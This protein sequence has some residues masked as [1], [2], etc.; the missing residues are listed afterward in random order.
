MNKKERIGLRTWI[1]VD[2]K[3][4]AHNFN[5]F[6]SLISKKTKLMAV[7]KSNAYGHSIID[8]AREM[9]HLGADFLGVDS[10]VEGLALRKE[11]INTPILVLGYTL[12][13]MVVSALENNISLS[14]SNF[15][16][17]E[18][19]LANQKNFNKS[20]N[21]HIK[22]DT[23]MHRQGFLKEDC[24]KVLKLLKSIKNNKINIEGLF[25]HFASA[26]NPSFP[27]DTE[28]QVENFKF[29]IKEFKENNFNPIIH[30]SA[31]GGT[32]LFPAY[33]FDMVR[34]GIGLYGLWPAKEVKHALSPKI[35]LKPILVW[36]SLISEIKKIPKGEHVGYDLTEFLEVNTVLGVVPIGYWHGYPRA[37]SSIGRI[38][39][40]GIECRVLGRVSMDMICIDI[41]KI[42]N[43]KV[44]D[45]II[46]VGNNSESLCSMEGINAILDISWYETI[47]RL[48]PLIK[49]LYI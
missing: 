6:R 23:G 13:E 31:T 7:I 21:I 47:T 8:F 3:S 33:H 12:P 35:I 29:W 45:E 36:K 14:I 27:K 42:K 17:L 34:I 43:P 48:N 37:L 19:I 10:I 15:E 2:K 18:Y 46:I 28:M 40:G 25:T 38:L 22:I 26:K 1:E 30:A 44:G 11:G 49:R 39:V 41:A 32:M 16:S 9:E 20:L 24:K 5:V 4:I